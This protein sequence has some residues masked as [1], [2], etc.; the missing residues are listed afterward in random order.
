MPSGGP[1]AG[2]KRRR[3]ARVGAL[4]ACSAKGWSALYNSLR[5]C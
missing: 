4:Q 3:W 1:P 5:M 2:L